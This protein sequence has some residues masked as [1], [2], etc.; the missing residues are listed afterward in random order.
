MSE[1]VFWETTLLKYELVRELAVSNMAL[2]FATEGHLQQQIS[3]I[4]T[5]ASMTS[6]LCNV[7]QF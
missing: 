6:S 1:T 3:I 5:P 4:L 7:V 2:T